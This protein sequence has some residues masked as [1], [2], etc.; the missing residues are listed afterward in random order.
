MWRFG[1]IA[2]LVFIALEILFTSYYRACCPQCGCRSQNVCQQCATPTATL[3]YGSYPTPTATATTTPT[4]TATST[5]IC[6]DGQTACGSTCVSLQ[7]DVNNCGGCGNVCNSAHASGEACT[8][9]NCTIVVCNPGFADCDGVAANGCEVNTQTDLH[10]CGGCGNVCN[11]A[12]ATGEACTAGNC[13]I[14]VCNPGFAD[15]DGV[16][17]NGCEVNTETDLHNCGTC[18]HLCTGGTTCSAGSCL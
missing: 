12:H 17:A 16:A 1:L 18:G 13:T 4:P 15:C 2:A 9:G 6:M 5:T 7:T 10:N 8:A 14:V 11:S 3:V